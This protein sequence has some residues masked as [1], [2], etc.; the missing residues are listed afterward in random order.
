MYGTTCEDTDRS[1]ISVGWASSRLSAFAYT[2]FSSILIAFIIQHSPGALLF[3]I[4]LRKPPA[5]S[6]V[7]FGSTS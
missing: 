1:F 4:S 7:I 5:S 3:I 2:I 6:V